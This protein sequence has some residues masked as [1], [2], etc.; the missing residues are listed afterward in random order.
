MTMTIHEIHEEII[1]VIQDST[2]TEVELTMQTHIV[3]EMNL[4]SIEA[5]MMISDLEDRFG[6][7]I[8]SGKLRDVRTIGDLCEIV[9]DALK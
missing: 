7:S 8:P 5:M 1:A 3:N 2:E 6:I 4:S 9:V